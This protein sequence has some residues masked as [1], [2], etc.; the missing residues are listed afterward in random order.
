VI[1]DGF[2][3]TRDTRTISM[4]QHYQP[5]IVLQPVG[6]TTVEVIAT[7]M[8][9][10]DPTSVQTSSNY[11]AKRIDTLPVPRTPDGMAALTPG[12]IA[13]GIGG[14]IQVRGAQTSGNLY[15]VDGQNLM[16]NAYNNLQYPIIEDAIEE[17]QVITGA[18]SAEYGNVDGGVINTIT[19]SGGNEFSGLLRT[20]LSNDKWNAVRPYQNRNAIV[21]YLS[22]DMNF[23][24]G[25]Y[26]L[27]DKLWFYL[28]YFTSTVKTEGNISSSAV[29]YPQAA[30]DAGRP[31]IGRNAAYTNEASSDR[32]QAK[33]TYL[34]NQDHYLVGTFNTSS[35]GNTKRNYSAGDLNALIPQDNS[36]SFWNL[37][38]R[39]TWSPT[40]TTEARIG[41][42]TQLY[43]TWKGVAKPDGGPIY[44]YGYNGV[45]RG[46]RYNVGIF[47]EDGGDARDNM[48]VNLK[49][50]YF[51]EWQGTHEL[52]FGLDY[53]DGYRKSRN[54]Q[55][56]WNNTTTYALNYRYN[57]TTF[58]PEAAP[59][60]ELC[61]SSTDASA[62]QTSVGLYI[63]DKWKVNGNIALQIGLRWDTYSADATDAGSIAS[64][65]GISPRLGVTYDVLGDQTWL[66]KGSYCR[67]NSAVLETIT[68]AVSGSGN[69]GYTIYMWRGPGGVSTNNYR[70]LS[71]VY[72]VAYYPRTINN[73]LEFYEPTAN[74]KVNPDMKAP[75]CDEIQLGATYAFNFDNWGAGY[76]TLTAVKK[77]WKNLIDARVGY[78]GK[79]NVS[80]FLPGYNE[81][82]YYEY[83]DNEPDAK[84]DYKALELSGAYQKSGFQ[85]SG[86]V[87]WSTLQGN[88][89]GE[90]SNTP[91]SGERIHTMDYWTN[92][93]TG[94][95]EQIYDYNLLTPYGYLAAHTPIHI[96][97]TADYTYATKYGFT[98]LGWRYRFQSGQHYDH[99]R[100]WDATLL[101][102]VFRYYYDEDE[103]DTFPINPAESM[104]FGDNFTQ[105][106]SSVR[107]PYAFNS[108]AY[109]D[110]ALTHDFN[111]FKLAGYNVRVFGKL[112]INNV[113][114]HQQLASWNTSMQSYN[115][116]KDHDGNATL[117]A[118]ATSWQTA[119]WIKGANYGKSEGQGYWGGARSLSLSLGFRF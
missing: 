91:G 23:T 74:V 6:N 43:E 113:F 40:F 112:L 78:N 7:S 47:S 36:F 46:L 57:P 50:S 42:K 92:P 63:N 89:E 16:D 97:L 85:F 26:V 9:A 71:D 53:Y 8:T 49:G 82:L 1:K 25:G 32:L 35:S 28:S 48:T 62:G 58:L 2:Q 51:T 66:L 52:D 56:P 114:N 86:N 41:A 60:F 37:A 33:L 119:P 116:N 111:M 61:W 21:D 4:D 118:G 54:E 70:P 12:V 109:H 15:L 83:W 44:N 99:Y 110:I 55:S 30:I 90:G 27:K 102:P 105:Y 117:P 93:A 39:A 14:R 95:W 11:D 94:K 87:T 13:N 76:V 18:I 68:S 45:G 79:V 98:T 22:K 75:T 101:S 24:V 104:G 17:T 77:T 115:A 34:I 80:Q 59:Y 67:Y 5:R 103:D 96:R 19:K 29:P 72:N 31:N 107:S 64:A 65:S 84:R 38:W 108:T 3:T 100:T 106:D 69:P 73:V 10:V 81:E 20:N 88:Y